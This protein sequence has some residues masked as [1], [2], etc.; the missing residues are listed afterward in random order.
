MIKKLFIIIFLLLTATASIG[1]GAYVTVHLPKGISL[2][3][4]R[5]WVSLSNNEKIDLTAFAEAAA[6]GI[7]DLED[8][9]EILHFA[10]N[11]HN[12]E[13]K[14]EALV[15]LRYYPDNKLTQKDVKEE[16]YDLI[17]AMA[18]T[19]NESNMRKLLDNVGLK[20][21]EWKGMRKESIGGLIAI[22]TEYRRTG[23]F[24]DSGR[25]RLMMF[26]NGKD[27]FHMTVSY[28][29]KK[30]NSFMLEAITDKIVRSLS[31]GR[32]L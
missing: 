6:E 21:L 27:S 15:N 30:Y 1:E 10:A 32:D 23:S 25:V 26:N 4:P 16:M 11:Y 3:V 12:K 17:I 8:E 7:I 28:D 9:L 2:D 19:Q 29:D 14:T 5:N 18:D 20:V 24:A 22:V 13:G 31:I